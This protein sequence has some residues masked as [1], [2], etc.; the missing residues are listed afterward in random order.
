MHNL[1]LRDDLSGIPDYKPGK[2]VAASAESGTGEVFK[3]SSNENPYAP[4]PSV[5]AAVAARID[6]INRYPESAATE[7]TAMLC[8]RFTVEPV[9]IVLGSGSVEVVSQLIRATAGEGDEVLFAW[10]SFEAYP[11]LVR[12]AGA[13]PVAVPLTAAHG[14]DLDAM[15][16]AIT[17]RTRL[18]LVCN[19]NNPTG[20]TLGHDELDA[21]VAQVPSDIVVVIDEAYVQFNLRED[22]PSGIEFFRRY[23][24]VAVAHTFSKAYGLAGLRVGYA[25]APTP[26]ATA[27][28]KVALPFGVT[29]LAQTAAVASLLAE[30]E[31]GD[32]VDALIAERERVV[33]AAIAQGWRLPESG[34]N[35]LWLPL[36]EH[37]SAAAALLEEHGLLVRPFAGEGLRA[38]I[39]ETEANDRLIVAMAALIELGLTGGLVQRAA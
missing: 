33:D 29:A 21:F 34:A 19:P 2:A 35:F 12:A 20:T 4:L 8:E 1:R 14:H 13:S 37:T 3:I 7:L 15:L 39:A 27:L 5:A 30:D 25:I 31:L 9:N 32:R 17:E 38:S 26:L 22:S 11:M 23:P 24:N 28:R 6:G 10:R 16:A 36:G 18:I